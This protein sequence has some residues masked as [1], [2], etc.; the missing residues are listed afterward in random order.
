MHSRILFFFII[1]FF[2]PEHIL[3]SVVFLTSFVTN[4]THAGT[5]CFNLSV[6]CLLECI[7]GW[8]KLTTYEY[9]AVGSGSRTACQGFSGDPG[10]PSLMKNFYFTEILTKQYYAVS[11]IRVVFSHELSLPLPDY[12]YRTSWKA[13][14]QK[15]QINYWNT[16]FTNIN[17]NEL[18][19]QYDK[20]SLITRCFTVSN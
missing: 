16:F 12:T 10:I 5:S 3:I 19:L 14:V 7:A 8:N 11:R 4:H 9:S 6:S 1:F 18:L 17:H 13:V 20:F 2:Y 15:S